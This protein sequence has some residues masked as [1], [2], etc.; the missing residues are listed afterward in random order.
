MLARFRSW[1][2]DGTYTADGRVFDVGNA[3]LSALHTGHGCDGEFDNG[4]GSLMR[5][6]PLAFT[7]ATDSQ[8]RDVSAITHAHE[9]SKESCVAFVGILRGILNGNRLSEVIEL[10]IPNDS[11]FD[12]LHNLKDMPRANVRSGGFVLDTLTAAL[13]CALHTNNYHDCVL[14]AV[15]LGSDT[16]TTACVAGAL[17]GALYGLED[18]PSEWIAALR[19]KDVIEHIVTID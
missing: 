3:T 14:E 6:A 18:I 4:N 11:R 10:N 2:Y 15:N 5:I 16:D 1:L 17:A 12:F 8:I 13:W 9:I 7:D 19:G